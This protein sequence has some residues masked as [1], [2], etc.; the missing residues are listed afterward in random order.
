MESFDTRVSHITV[1]H[2]AIDTGNQCTICGE[3]TVPMKE[4]MIGSK[5]GA[6]SRYLFCKKHT[7][8]LI[9]QLEFKS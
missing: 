9:N 7:Q 5:W 4:V 3:T 8:S 1:R 6:N 2:I